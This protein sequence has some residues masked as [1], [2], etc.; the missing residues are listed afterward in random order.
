MLTSRTFYYSYCTVLQKLAK[1]EV[2]PLLFWNVIILPPLRFYVK[3]NFG[4]FKQSK[5]DIFGNC[6]DSELWIL[7]NLGL[8]SCSNL[9]KSKF[10]TSKIAKINIFGLFEFPKLGFHVTSECTVGSLLKELRN[11]LKTQLWCHFWLNLG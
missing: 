7:V 9:L 11:N 2:K 4:E 6:R 8:E 3:S 1:C 10:G 5:N